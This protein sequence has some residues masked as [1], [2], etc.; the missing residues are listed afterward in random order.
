MLDNI[1]LLVSSISLKIVCRENGRYFFGGLSPFFEI[2][3]YLCHT[4]TT[5]CALATKN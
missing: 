5:D 1:V 2:N 3:H 4:L